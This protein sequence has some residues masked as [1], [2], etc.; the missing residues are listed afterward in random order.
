MHSDIIVGLKHVNIVYFESKISNL[1]KL[2]LRIFSSTFRGFCV[3]HLKVYL[4]K[5]VLIVLCGVGVI[6]VGLN[7]V[8]C[9]GWG[10]LCM[11]SR[12]PNLYH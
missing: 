4:I 11:K 1:D 12:P 6:I 2:I 8:D 5:L 10:G 3:T 9:D 7:H